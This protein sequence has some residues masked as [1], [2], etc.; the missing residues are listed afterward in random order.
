MK[1]P[2]KLKKLGPDVNAPPAV[3]ANPAPKK[4]KAPAR[5][6]TKGWVS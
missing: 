5:P 3:R 2:K 6:K 4:P 1:T